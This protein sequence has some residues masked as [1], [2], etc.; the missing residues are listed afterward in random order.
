MRA[1]RR[2]DPFSTAATTRERGGS[3]PKERETRREEDTLPYFSRGSIVIF[4]DWIPRSQSLR[5]VAPILRLDCLEMFLR[6]ACTE[7]PMPVLFPSFLLAACFLRS[8]QPSCQSG[9]TFH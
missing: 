6:K 9:G 1:R 5:A 7:E 3:G 8:S 2:T 4:I